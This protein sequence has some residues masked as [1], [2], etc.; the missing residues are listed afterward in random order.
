MW[1]NGWGEAMTGALGVNGTG[2]AETTLCVNGGFW[3]GLRLQ[4]Q[5]ASGNDAE[6]L[7][8]MTPVF[9]DV[10]VGPAVWRRVGVDTGLLLGAACVAALVGSQGFASAES[11]FENAVGVVVGGLVYT[12]SNSQALMAGGVPV[13]YRLTLVPPV[14]L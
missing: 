10:P 11:M 3:V 5:A 12:I 1:R 6:Q 7:G 2:I 8:L 9:Q 13:S 14:R 4:G